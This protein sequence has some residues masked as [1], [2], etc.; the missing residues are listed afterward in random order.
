MLKNKRLLTVKA[1]EKTLEIMELLASGSN[2]LHIGDLAAK[3]SLSRNEALLLLV[4]LE[5][6]G[7]V[8][9]DDSG[10]IYTPG[11]KF[12][13]LASHFLGRCGTNLSDSKE[14]VT[15]SKPKK[16]PPGSRKPIRQSCS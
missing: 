16:R 4:T 14:P 8:S 10:R 11:L 7:V 13:E 6:R 5:N 1:A 15:C 9:W 12:T 3:L 2:K